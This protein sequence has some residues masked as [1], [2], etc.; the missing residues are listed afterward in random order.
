MDSALPIPTYRPLDQILG[1]DRAITTLQSA[2]RADRVHHA[3]IFA[4]PLGVGK[5]T[6]AL[7]FA[8]ILLDPNAGPN[9][10][11][12]FDTDPDGEVASLVRRGAHPDLH[13][14]QK[15][16]AAISAESTLRSRK[17]I[18]I[19]IDLIRERMVGGVA[20]SGKF[21]DAIAWQR[22]TM[23]KAKV[24]IIDEAE[25]L[26]GP[27]Q[28][29]ILKTLEE[30]PPDT[31]IILVTSSEDRLLPTIRSRAQRAL[32]APL[33]TQ[34][35]RAWLDQSD[36]APSPPQQ[37]WIERYAQGSPGRATIALQTGIHEWAQFVEPIA[38]PRRFDAAAPEALAKQIE[39]WA[40]EWVKL[41]PN[42]SKEAANKAAMNHALA[43]L[44]E[45]QRAAL[46]EAST[47]EQAQRAAR[48]VELI[49]RAESHAR[50]NVNLKFVM[51]NL[52][53][54]IATN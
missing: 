42:A 24:F 49:A 2:L 38:H 47:P 53:A 51:E 40:K 27:A 48:A 10:A 12:Q 54:S 44:A 16:L 13:L 6:T 4:G 18:S 43:M 9:L 1:Q 17:Q 50:Q 39:E 36:L 32:F 41:N 34:S 8:A 25:L 33:D 21:Y 26:A 37:Q 3:W 30:P 7:A 11:G 28:N 52:A 5:C 35:M 46:R 19:P 23:G 14:I 20:D 29:A 45:S 22:P 31:Y 15:E